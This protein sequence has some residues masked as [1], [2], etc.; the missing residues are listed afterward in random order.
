MASFIEIDGTRHAID[1]ATLELY[2]CA[3]SEADWNLELVGHDGNVM[4]LAGT[5][6]AP[7]AASDLVGSKLRLDPRSLDEVAEALLGDAITIYPNGAEVCEAFLE[8]DTASACSLRLVSSFAFDW[9]RAIDQPGARYAEPRR[10]AFEILASIGP[11][12]AGN[13]P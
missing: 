9:D 2:H 8:V 6:P 4:Y 11:L 10:V 12:H 5:V 13:L 3:G 1:D 7:K